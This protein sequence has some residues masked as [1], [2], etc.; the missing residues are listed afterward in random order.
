MET[1]Y[2]LN[3]KFSLPWA[4]ELGEVYPIVIFKYVNT[5]CYGFD[6]GVHNRWSLT[7]CRNSQLINCAHHFSSLQPMYY[8]YEHQIGTS[9][10]HSSPTNALSPISIIN[11]IKR[12]IGL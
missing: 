3:S 2:S 6:L 5:I 1:E 12:E 8:F 4:K 7:D 9:L 11:Q 10:I